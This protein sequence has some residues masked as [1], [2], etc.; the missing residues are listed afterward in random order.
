ME[1]AEL[2]EANIKL[3]RELRWTQQQSI[4][5]EAKLA[6]LETIAFSTHSAKAYVTDPGLIAAVPLQAA[7]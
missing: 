6:K 4:A 3:T 2:H 7:S 5:A 1:L